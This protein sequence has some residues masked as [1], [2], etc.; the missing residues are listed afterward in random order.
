MARTSGPLKICNTIGT[1]LDLGQPLA[2]ANVSVFFLRRISRVKTLFPCIFRETPFRAD[3]L[4]SIYFSPEEKIYPG[5]KSIQGNLERPRC[6]RPRPF[7]WRRHSQ[8]GSKAS[9]CQS[10][11]GRRPSTPPHRASFVIWSVGMA[12]MPQCAY[13]SD[14]GVPAEFSNLLCGCELP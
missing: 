6:A 10:A 3:P 5:Q 1:K 4:F 12:A 13:R 8:R 2:L 14:V 11:S 7:S 9:P